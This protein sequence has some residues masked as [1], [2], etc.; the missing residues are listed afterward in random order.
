MKS[1]LLLVLLLALGACA[2]PDPQAKA[3]EKALEARVAKLESQL[4][5]VQTALQRVQAQAAGQSGNSQQVA[6][7]AAAQFCAT[8]LASSLEEYRQDNAR[9]P[10]MKAVSLPRACDGFRVAWSQL[11]KA[12]YRFGV[13]GPSGSELAGETR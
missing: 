9:F 8:Q 3:R 13:S 11:D 10:A 2:R 4:A 7:R 12:H 5:A 6:A 1:A